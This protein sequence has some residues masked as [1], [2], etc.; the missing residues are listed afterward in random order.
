M[1]GKK[2]EFLE[3]RQQANVAKKNIIEVPE[4]YSPLSAESHW[5]TASAGTKTFH[6]V[7]EYIK[8]LS[9]RQRMTLKKE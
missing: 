3:I 4:G 7:R 6:F 9:K 1:K 2:Y 8:P 5:G